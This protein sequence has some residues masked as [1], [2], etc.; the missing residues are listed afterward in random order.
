NDLLDT[1]APW[2]GNNSYVVSNDLMLDST[3]VISCHYER[4]HANP[5]RLYVNGALVDAYGSENYSDPDYV[6]R[7]FVHSGKIGIG[8]IYQGAR[9]NDGPRTENTGY[10]LNGHIG[11]MLYYND[12]G[13]DMNTARIRIVH[14]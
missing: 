10:F 14:N 3:Y 2:G 7:L 8:G 5:L 9:F 4:G 11:E 12:R 13:S 1:L 6:G